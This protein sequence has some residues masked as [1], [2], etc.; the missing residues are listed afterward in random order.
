MKENSSSNLNSSTTDSITR[1]EEEIDLTQIIKSLLRNKY[2]I[3]KIATL[4]IVISVAYAITRDPVWEGQFE[5]VLANNQAS[6]SQTNRILQ[7]NSGLANLIGVGSDNNQLETEVQILES[8]SVLKPVFDFVKAQKQQQGVDTKEWRYADWLDGKLTIQLVKG[9]S[10][11]QL[12]YRDTDKKLVLPVIQKISEAYQTYSGRDRKRGINQAVKYLDNQIKVYTKKSTLSLRA[13]QEYGIKYDLTYLQGGGGGVNS[14]NK[15]SLNIEIIRITAANQIRYINEQIDQLNQI[16]DQAE[17]LIYVGRSIPELAEESAELDK[18]EVDLAILRANFTDA[19]IS[20]RKL[21]EKR[22]L[23]I[24]VF[25]KK[26]YGYLYAQRTA[27]HARLKA[28]DRPKGVLLKYRELLRTSARDEETLAKLESDRQMLA[29]EQARKEDPW[30]LISTPTLLDK[31]VA[32]NKR[33]IVG[34]GLM[35]G[36]ALGSGAALLSDQRTDLVFSKNELKRLLPCPLIEHLP[37]MA[38]EQWTDAADL[39]AAGPLADVS[40]NSA[41]A[42]IPLGKMPHEQLQAFISEISRAINERELVVSTD[43]RK[44]RRCATQLIVTS[45][46]VAT[47]KEISQFCQKL[48]L[49]GAPLAGWVLLDPELDLG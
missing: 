27:A 30:E 46:G 33:R 36:L 12:S 16:Q 44:T 15:N 4:S 6:T 21:L 47:R 5:I 2:L 35:A 34:L 42:L 32:P 38:H 29:L 43:L 41:I 7:N 19:D 8:P 20:V 31:P 39:L 11:L 22:R 24:D 48:A 25:Q 13:A 10:V 18:I 23:L 3:A 17:A 45:Q 28:A 1:L 9:T 49:Q 26:T 40:G 37:A 14:E